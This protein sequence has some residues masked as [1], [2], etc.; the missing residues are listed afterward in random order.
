MGHS[1]GTVGAQNWKLS[2]TVGAQL[3]HK[4]TWGTVGAQLRQNQFGH[5]WHTVDAQLRHT[6]GTL[7]HNLRKE[8][9]KAS[10]G[11]IGAYFRHIWALGHSFISGTVGAQT[12]FTNY[13][14]HFLI[15]NSLYV[16]LIKPPYYYPSLLYIIHYTIYIIHYTL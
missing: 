5:S 12:I 11:T 14:R 1:W 10:L 7:G 8:E 15:L 6:W 9:R 3:G 13:G 4:V 2:C 16:T